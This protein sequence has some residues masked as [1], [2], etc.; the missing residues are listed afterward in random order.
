MPQP[1]TTVRRTF[2]FFAKKD[3][4]GEPGET[5]YQTLRA[6]KRT[7]LL[8]EAVCAALRRGQKQLAGYQ[9]RT[10][11]QAVLRRESWTV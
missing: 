11:T 7:S 6:K 4:G 5:F 3:T 9:T 2:L 10:I 8:L 1:R